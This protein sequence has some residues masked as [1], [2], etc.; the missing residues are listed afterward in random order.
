MKKKKKNLFLALRNAWAAIVCCCICK[1]GGCMIH[2]CEDAL[3]SV[4]NWDG[5]EQADALCCYC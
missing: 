5:R 1:I 3:S 4:G 2:F